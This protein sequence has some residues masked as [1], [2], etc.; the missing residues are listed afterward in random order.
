MGKEITMSLQIEQ[1]IC[2]K[3]NIAVILH[4]EA[5]RKTLAID[6]PDATKMGA[7]LRDR[8]WGLDFLLITHHH[9]DHTSGIATLK[10]EWGTY[11]VGPEFE[12]DK[13]DH[14]DRLVEEGNQIDFAAHPIEV[15][16]TPGHTAGGISYYLPQDGL[17]FTGDTLFS[18]GIGR[19]FECSAD[20]MLQ[21]L[22][23]LKKLPSKTQIYC[24]HDYT[25]NNGC[26]ALSVDGDNPDLHNRLA[27]VDICH[28]KRQI[29]LPTTLE[30]ELQTNPF[31]RYD[32]C[33]IITNLKMV[34]CDDVA[35][36]AELRRRKDVF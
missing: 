17:V 22:K 7:V 1:F 11:V 29:T 12:A 13:I 2:R 14:L 4:D 26:F 25:K 18:L 36:L 32:N 6:A 31:L 8:G 15:I 5:S 20:I 35:V 24:G 16:A 21:S 33:N 10:Q 30:V 23:K 27:Q 9:E 3:D 34:G 28:Q 19:L